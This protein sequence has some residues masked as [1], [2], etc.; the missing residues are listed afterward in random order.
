MPLIQQKN[1]R[2]SIKKVTF[3]HQY[4]LKEAEE[5]SKSLKNR[6]IA[7]SFGSLDS[8]SASRNLSE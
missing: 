8:C 3:H 7:K 6:I 5:N 4:V 1:P 2:D